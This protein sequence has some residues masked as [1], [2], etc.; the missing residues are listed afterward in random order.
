MLP[1]DV[2]INFTCCHRTAGFKIAFALF[3]PLICGNKALKHIV[4]PVRSLWSWFELSLTNVP[5]LCV[6]CRTGN[7]AP[8]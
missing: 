6:K 4:I 7:A 8:V 3:F 2:F 5:T 1:K